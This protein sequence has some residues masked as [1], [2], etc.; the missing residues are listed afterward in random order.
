MLKIARNYPILCAC[1]V[2]ALVS[3][4]VLALGIAFF[5]A[6]AAL[7]ALI[8]FLVAVFLTFA[9]LNYNVFGGRPNSSIHQPGDDDGRR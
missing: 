2:V 4:S 5:D 3:V 7:V 6:T 1:A 9:I 8:T